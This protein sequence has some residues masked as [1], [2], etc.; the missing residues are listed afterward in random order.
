MGMR[1]MD[2]KP[3]ILREVA[4]WT[5]RLLILALCPIAVSISLML[6]AMAEVSAEPACDLNELVPME[7]GFVVSPDGK[8][9]TH[10]TSSPIMIPCECEVPSELRNLVAADPRSAAQAAVDSGNPQFLGVPMLG[11]LWPI[12]LEAGEYDSFSREIRERLVPVPGMS[13]EIICFEQQKLNL[14]ARSYAE[15]YN[16]IIA[17]YYSRQEPARDSKD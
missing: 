2:Q 14:A 9:K 7:G 6:F 5:T 12:G 16:R 15:T 3:S 13:E 17:E 8:I 1:V 11:G 10:E 4:L